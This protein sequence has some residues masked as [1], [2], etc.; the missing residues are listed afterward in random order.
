MIPYG[1]VTIETTKMRKAHT[2]NK[3]CPTFIWGFLEPHLGACSRRRR[4]TSITFPSEEEV[5]QWA[6]GGESGEVI[7]DF[8][9]VFV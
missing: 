1:A 2:T 8:R 4:G 9:D 7:T 3:N 5:G 6:T